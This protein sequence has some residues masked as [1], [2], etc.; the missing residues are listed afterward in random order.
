MWT[1]VSHGQIVNDVVTKIGVELNIEFERPS[2][3]MALNYR[4][5]KWL[6]GEYGSQLDTR[7]SRWGM[8]TNRIVKGPEWTE[9]H[10]KY[11]ERLERE[12]RAAVR[13]LQDPFLDER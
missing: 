5:G 2:T 7:V 12:L 9:T 3:A 4:T 8:G 11:R 10:D 6:Y 1:Q 13:E